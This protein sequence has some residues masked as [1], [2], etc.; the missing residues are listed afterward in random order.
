MDNPARRHCLPLSHSLS[1]THTLSHTLSPSVSLTHSRS[2]SHSLT[3]SL[4]LSLA[5]SLL[6]THW[7]TRRVVRRIPGRK[8]RGTNRGKLGDAG[9]ERVRATSNSHVPMVAAADEVADLVRFDGIHV[10]AHAK[11]V[12]RR[13]CKGIKFSSPP[14]RQPRGKLTVSLVNS[15]TNATKIGWHMWEIDLRFAPRLPPGCV[16]V[17]DPRELVTYIWSHCKVN[18]HCTT[19]TYGINIRTYVGV[20]SPAKIRGR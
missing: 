12:D 15:N 14:W 19:T 7:A 6:H 16:S 8:W 10:A 4:S 9:L 5:L 11:M 3:L 13:V 18:S 1:H 17:L 20:P 2:L